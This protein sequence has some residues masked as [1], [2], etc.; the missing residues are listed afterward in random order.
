MDTELVFHS[1]SFSS[2]TSWDQTALDQFVS[3]SVGSLPFY[4]SIMF[5]STIY[6]AWSYYNII[7]EI[8][9]WLN[10]KQLLKEK[11]KKPTKIDFKFF[12]I[13]SQIISVTSVR[14]SVFGQ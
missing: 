2:L 13:L 7:L 14:S 12:C 9:T 5:F 6:I 1:H 8:Y 4:V 10:V 3:T 11:K